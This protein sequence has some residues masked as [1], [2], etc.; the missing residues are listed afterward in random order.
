VLGEEERRGGTTRFVDSSVERLQVRVEGL[1]PARTSS[2][3]TG[4]ACR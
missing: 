4:D 2:P 1:N 3:A